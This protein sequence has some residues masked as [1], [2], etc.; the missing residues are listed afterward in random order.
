MASTLMSALEWAGVE[1]GNAELGDR[2]RCRRLVQVAAKFAQNPHG[3]L[4]GLLPDGR[5][6]GG[7]SVAGTIGCQL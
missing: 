3:T 2:R 4:P 5:S 1:F 7:V 6:E